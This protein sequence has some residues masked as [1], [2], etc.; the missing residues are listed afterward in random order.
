[1]PTPSRESCRR[2][3]RSCLQVFAALPSLDKARFAFA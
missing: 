3:D 2:C 1:M